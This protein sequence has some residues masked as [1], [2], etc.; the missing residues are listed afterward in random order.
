MGRTERE[1]AVHEN[2]RLSIFAFIT[3]T[4]NSGL[5][6]KQMVYTVIVLI[7]VDSLHADAAIE[8]VGDILNQ[9]KLP[10]RVRAVLSTPLKDVKQEAMERED[11]ANI[12]FLSGMHGQ[13]KAF[14]FLKAYCLQEDISQEEVIAL[15]DRA[16]KKLADLE[17]E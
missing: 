3:V 13:E 10:H 12:G 16:G 5:K 8:L 7:E 9:Y 6:G 4:H 17:V 1:F 15:M 2:D 14:P 11:A